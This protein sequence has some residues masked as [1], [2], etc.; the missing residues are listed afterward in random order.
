MSLESI[1]TSATFPPDTTERMSATAAADLVVL[2]WFPSFFRPFAISGMWGGR[3]VQVELT[4]DSLWRGEAIRAE[5]SFTDIDVAE[6][7]LTSCLLKMLRAQPGDIACV[8][9]GALCHRPPV[10]GA[11]LG[12][13]GHMRVPVAGHGEGLL[14]LTCVY[15]SWRPGHVE[16][17]VSFPVAGYPL[18]SHGPFRAGDRRIPETPFVNIVEENQKHLLRTIAQLPKVLAPIATGLDWEKLGR[19][20]GN[21]Q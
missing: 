15:F 4:A 2:N 18:T 11:E 12:W 20:I 1:D 7:G 10:H 16:I 17:T 19:M 3:E 21:G 9:R 5:R 8:I 6:P 13:Y 14:G